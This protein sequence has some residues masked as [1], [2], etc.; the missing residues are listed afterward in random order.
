MVMM[1]DA[2]PWKMFVERAVVAINLAWS[3]SYM[4]LGIFS[5]I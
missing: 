5:Y 1:R 4:H 2:R 3:F